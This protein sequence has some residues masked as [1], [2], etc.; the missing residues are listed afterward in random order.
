[1]ITRL[2]QLARATGSLVDVGTSRSLDV[3]LSRLRRQLLQS[4]W[5]PEW[6]QQEMLRRQ[7]LLLDALGAIAQNP[8]DAAAAGRS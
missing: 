1:M 4:A 5:T 3:R 6:G 8:Q 2:A 7:Q